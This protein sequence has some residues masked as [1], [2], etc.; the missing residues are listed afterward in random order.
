VISKESVWFNLQ[1][2]IE[3]EEKE[4][5]GVIEINMMFINNE[6]VCGFS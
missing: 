1:R 5:I 4:V 2:K 6:C 3:G